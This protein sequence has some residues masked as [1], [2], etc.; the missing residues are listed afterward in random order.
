MV[1]NA[2]PPIP[3]NQLAVSSSGGTTHTTNTLTSLV[4]PKTWSNCPS[5]VAAI[6]STTTNR[7][8][9]VESATNPSLAATS[10]ATSM[11]TVTTSSA[12][13]TVPQQLSYPPG[14]HPSAPASGQYPNAGGLGLNPSGAAQPGGPFPDQLLQ[15]NA[16]LLRRELDARFIASQDRSI[17]IPPPPYMRGDHSHPTQTPLPSSFLQ[18]LVPGQPPPPSLFDPKY[19]AKLD[20]VAALKYPGSIPGLPP[21]AS[22][23]PPHVGPPI[24]NHANTPT[25][26]TPF[27]SINPTSSTSLAAK[28]QPFQK[29]KSN[30]T[31]KWCAMHVRIA[32]EIYNHQQKN[33]QATSQLSNAPSVASKGFIQGPPPNQGR[34]SS[35]SDH[36]PK[37]EAVTKNR[38]GSS[39]SSVSQSPSSTPT[40]RDPPG[41]FPNLMPPGGHGLPRHPSGPPNTSPAAISGGNSAYPPYPF[42]S[43]LALPPGL[44]TSVNQRTSS[45]ITSSASMKHHAQ[46]QHGHPALSPSPKVSQSSPFTSTSR[47]FP[48][49]TPFPGAPPFGA[50]PPPP[51]HGLGF[52][53][54]PGSSSMLQGR[55]ALSM[56]PYRPQMDQYRLGL[57]P[58]APYG[59]L[60]HHPSAPGLGLPPGMVQGWGGLKAEAEKEDRERK[61][62]EHL[63]SQKKAHEEIKQRERDRNGHP[64]KAATREREPRVKEEPEQQSS[65]KA[66]AKP[67]DD[68]AMRLSAAASGS[69]GVLMGAPHALGVSMWPT[70]PPIPGDYYRAMMMLGHP[71]GGDRLRPEDIEKIQ[72]YE[73]EFERSKLLSG[74][75]G[76]PNPPFMPPPGGHPFLPGL[77]TPQG[78]PGLRHKLGVGGPG[79]P[80]MPMGV[81]PGVGVP[82]PLIPSA[83]GAPPGH[84]H[85]LSSM[86]PDK[87]MR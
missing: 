59:A 77:G 51:P 46:S 16:D 64:E 28:M 57:R 36:T 63:E 11:A 70:A 18:H 12:S 66:S 79:L 58:L 65:H 62:K 33:G 67:A 80:G 40:T 37:Q 42:L 8:G 30:K 83:P 39:T 48:P 19:A 74:I 43:N 69:T 82:P 41:V 15:P 49:A 21:G 4:F 23:Y 84:M 56:D 47:G 81:G 24:I 68:L 27:T 53:G 71:P 26:S 60:G 5:P 50:M 44:P 13:K 9:V 2:I 72:A 7:P 52:P 22:P 73:R 45:V 1:A 3:A 61:E 85:K 14:A 78:L 38:P 20:P 55:E 86:M 34:L 10:T 31:G 17:A 29:S 54:A 87:P 25:S 32:W 76:P 75:A 6:T 35:S